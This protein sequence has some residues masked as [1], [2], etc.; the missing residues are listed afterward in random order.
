MDAGAPTPQNHAISTR[1]ELMSRPSLLL[2]AGALTLFL[3]SAPDLEA[4]QTA[5]SDEIVEEALLDE[6]LDEEP[7]DEI[8]D[9]DP[10][11]APDYWPAGTDRPTKAIGTDTVPQ[12]HRIYEF[13]ISRTRNDDNGVRTNVDTAFDALVRT[14]LNERLEFRFGFAGYLSEDIEVAGVKRNSSGF[15]D[16][17]FGFKWDIDRDHDPDGLAVALISEFTLPTGA[18]GSG[19]VDPFVALA[20]SMSGPVGETDHSWGALA[21]VGVRWISDRYSAPTDNDYDQLSQLEYALVGS[22]NSL[23]VELFGDWGLSRPGGPRHSIGISRSTILP[24]HFGNLQTDIFATYGLSHDADDWSVGIG[25]SF[26]RD[27]V[28]EIDDDLEVDDD[29]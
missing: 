20:A 9:V 5:A 29:E 23:N 1:K 24:S 7:L 6:T 19:N 17:R 3:A 21:N 16:V 11:L 27:P 10:R 18:K 28:V 2:A 4:R 12:L 14:G 22:F 25:F 13:G 26:W 8:G 15:G